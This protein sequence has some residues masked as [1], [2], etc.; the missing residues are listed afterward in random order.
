[1][2]TTLDFF[3]QHLL[4]VVAYRPEFAENYQQESDETH[5]CGPMVIPLPSFID[6]HT[7]SSSLKNGDTGHL[8][9]TELVF[10]HDFHDFFCSTSVSSETLPLLSR[11]GTPSKHKPTT[12]LQASAHPQS[13]NL[14][15]IS[16]LVYTASQSTT[17]NGNA[18]TWHPLHHHSGAHPRLHTL[19]WLEYHLPDGTVYYVHPTSRVTT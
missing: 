8:I 13:R 15:S 10:F 19:G 4:I 17:S 6:H 1:M 2:L 14:T 7:S 16:P 11:P 9:E 18:N 5:S 12:Y 3:T